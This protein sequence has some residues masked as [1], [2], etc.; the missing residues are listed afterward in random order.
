MSFSKTPESS[1]LDHCDVAELFHPQMNPEYVE[2]TH[3]I[4][5]N[6]LCIS[7]RSVNGMELAGSSHILRI[8][9]QACNRSQ[10]SFGDPMTLV[11]N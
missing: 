7:S 4:L 11:E 5:R 10:G 6:V 1:L 3:D 2:I 8:L 9:E